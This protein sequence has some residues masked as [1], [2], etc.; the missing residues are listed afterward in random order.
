MRRWVF[1]LRSK[2]QSSGLEVH[3]ELTILTPVVTI[4]SR[5]RK[6]DRMG[7]SVSLLHTNYKVTDTSA[8]LKA[9]GISLCFVD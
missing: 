6:T 5:Y 4:R 3:D 8:T 1:G 7:W 2:K 9:A